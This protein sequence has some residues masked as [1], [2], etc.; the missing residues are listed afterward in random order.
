M[1][2]IGTPAPFKFD[3]QR[4]IM[5]LNVPEYQTDM[6][7]IKEALFQA[8]I[9][10]ANYM[11]MYGPY[12]NDL[13]RIEVCLTW[14][15][16]EVARNWQG[17]MM[18]PELKAQLCVT[19]KDAWTLIPVPTTLSESNQLWQET[20]PTYPVWYNNEK[21]ETEV[22]TMDDLAA[23]TRAAAT[24]MLTETEQV[25]THSTPALP[26]RADYISLAL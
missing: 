16:S 26:S 11:F 21:P 25:F 14:F 23:S 22:L 7:W 9:G 20:G 19:L 15:D 8:D 12:E 6:D 3:T 2:L 17:T 13:Y 18:D 24:L 4:R 5:L 10:I 1:A